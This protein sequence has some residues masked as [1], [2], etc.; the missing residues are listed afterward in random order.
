MVS[1]HCPKEIR[2]GETRDGHAR[3]GA[4]G[5][6]GLVRELQSGDGSLD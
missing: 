1:V 2:Y 4:D 3:N 6:D 5:V